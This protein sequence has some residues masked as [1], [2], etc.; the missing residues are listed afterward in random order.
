MT[1]WSRADE[2]A[3]CA[4]CGAADWARDEPAGEVICRACGVVARH[5]DMVD[6]PCLHHVF[7]PAGHDLSKH[8]RTL[9]DAVRLWAGLQGMEGEQVQ[10][11]ARRWREAF[12]EA[13]ARAAREALQEASRRVSLRSRLPE[14]T[15]ACLHEALPFPER[16]GLGGLAA[17][18]GVEERGAKELVAF[19]RGEY[20][21][22]PASDAPSVGAASGGAPSAGAPSGDAGA[23]SA[24]RRRA[25]T[26][27]EIYDRHTAAY[28]RQLRAVTNGLVDGAR[29]RMRVLRAAEAALRPALRRSE[30]AAR[31]QDAMVAAAFLFGAERAGVG[32]SERAVRQVCGLSAGYRLCAAL[33]DLRQAADAP[34]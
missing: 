34:P 11:L 9:L 24:P 4:D 2:D 10:A 21:R 32:C 29:Q 7:M 18:F 31:R 6:G 3:R 1:T 20:Y 8:D 30:V 15:V 17:A 14:L 16:F 26:R 27:D 23:P 13:K 25:L 5:H 22:P 28:L 12:S 19:V 33:A